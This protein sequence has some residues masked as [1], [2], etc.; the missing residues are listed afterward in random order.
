MQKFRDERAKEEK[1]LDL[2]VKE[3]WEKRLQLIQSQYEQDMKRKRDQKELSQRLQ[4]EQ[5]DLEK[6]MTLKRE[7]KREDAKR[8]LIQLEQEATASLVTKH[9]EEMLKLIKAKEAE[10]A[11]VNPETAK[12][13]QNDT[14]NNGVKLPQAWVII[15]N[16]YFN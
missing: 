7:R 4:K 9:S 15:K 10:V 11:G 8:M 13:M 5:Q 14:N 2:E 1:K 12:T 6:N 3:E 16:I